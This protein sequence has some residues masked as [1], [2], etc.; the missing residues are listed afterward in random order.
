[1]RIVDWRHAPVSKIFYRY[2]QGDDYE[3]EV[4]GRERVGEVTARR[5][6]RIRD[7]VLDRIEAPEGVFLAEPSG[8][9]ADRAASGRGC[10]GGARSA[11]RAYAEG[12]AG[13]RAGSAAT[14]PATAAAP[15]S[16]CPRSPA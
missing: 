8:W 11:L 2:Q 15:T 12:E 4:A 9:R 16:A 5:T 6:V 13:G 10:A 3:E 14:S 1:M 7:G